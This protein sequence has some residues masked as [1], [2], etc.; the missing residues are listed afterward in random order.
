M[1]F[2]RP[3]TSP[4]IAP[5]IDRNGGNSSGFGA[6]DHDWPLWDVEFGQ[7]NDWSW[8]VSDCH[9]PWSAASTFSNW[10][11]LRLVAS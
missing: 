11:P 5:P 4:N 10:P 7:L 3:A 2:Q 9:P 8:P 6:I 1:N